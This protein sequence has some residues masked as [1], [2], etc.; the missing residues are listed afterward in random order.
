MHT[1]KHN[2]ALIEEWKLCVVP[3]VTFVAL[4]AGF[5]VTTLSSLEGLKLQ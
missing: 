5:K 2:Q 3:V 4:A 1:N